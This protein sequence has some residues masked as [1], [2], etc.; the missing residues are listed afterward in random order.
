MGIIS[1]ERGNICGRE[2]LDMSE[3]EFKLTQERLAA[4]CKC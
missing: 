2:F 4:I 1:A 3:S